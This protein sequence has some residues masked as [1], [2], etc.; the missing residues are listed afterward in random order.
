LG[1]GDGDG[2]VGVLERTRKRKKK[3]KI[4]R[5]IDSPSPLCKLEFAKQTDRYPVD[6]Q[7]RI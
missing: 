1:I 7:F 5:R 2:E 6:F 4:R 3:G